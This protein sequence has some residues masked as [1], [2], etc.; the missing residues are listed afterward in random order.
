[1]NGAGL[2]SG[3]YILIDP[4]SGGFLAFAN[5]NPVVS[6][7]VIQGPPPPLFYLDDADFS[8]SNKTQ[9]LRVRAQVLTNAT[10]PARTF[11]VGLY[12]V[13]CAGAADEL[14][15]TLG[16]VVPGSAVA[17]A[18]PSASSVTQGNSGDFTIPS[19]GAF[20]LGVTTSGAPA[21]SSVQLI[22][23]YLQTRH[24]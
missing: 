5:G 3:T 13:T 24:V 11:T 8:I 1:M 14:T 6:S 10:A 18:S 23:G 2:G 12:P 9:K 15:F 17:I 20:A 19:D 4:K 22:Y 7:A 16:T 21:T